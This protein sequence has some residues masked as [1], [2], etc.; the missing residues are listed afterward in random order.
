M[1]NL[2]IVWLACSYANC[3]SCLYFLPLNF[4]SLDT[5][6]GS[7]SF[8]LHITHIFPDL[9]FPP[10]TPSPVRTDSSSFACP[11]P[12]PN[13]LFLCSPPV[14]LIISSLLPFFSCLTRLSQCLSPQDGIGY[15][16]S[17]EPTGIKELDDLSKEISHLQR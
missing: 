10:C 8:P 4:V 2:C 13:Q 15:T 1:C 14:T 16:G 9:F 7:T 17:T 12:S 11:F 5:T 3:V 6:A